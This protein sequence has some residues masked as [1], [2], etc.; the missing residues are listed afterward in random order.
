MTQGQSFVANVLDAIEES[1]Y[2]NSTAV[3]L[4]WDD[5]GGFYRHQAG[6]PKLSGL[7]PLG[8]SF[9]VP[10]MVISSVHSTRISEP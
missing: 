3:F 10:F 8:L 9:R 6:P 5:Y 4:T 7:N 2:W 1:R